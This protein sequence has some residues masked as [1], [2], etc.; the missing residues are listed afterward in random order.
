MQTQTLS[1]RSAGLYILL[2]AVTVSNAEAAPHRA[3]GGTVVGPTMKLFDANVSSCSEWFGQAHAVAVSIPASYL[4]ELIPAVE[5]GPVDKLQTGSWTVYDLWNNSVSKI[6]FAATDR[7]EDKL[8]AINKLYFGTPTPSVGQ[9]GQGFTAGHGDSGRCVTRPDFECFGFAIR[10][11]D[12]NKNVTGTSELRL[13]PSSDKCDRVPTAPGTCNF[14][15]ETLSIDF[16]P[17]GPSPA[18]K[19]GSLKVTCSGQANSGFQVSLGGGG[20]SLTSKDVTVKI[21]VDGH[22]LP[23]VFNWA[24]GSTNDLTVAATAT[25][26]SGASGPF[27]L[28]SVILLE[29]P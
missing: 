28:S 9:I 24:A 21:A 5:Y 16:G 6:S 12:A 14:T 22:P 27:R 23:Y 17:I 25:P 26:S 8:A 3:D 7:P 4:N 20:G 15:T 11:P 1:R 29:V 13:W 18:T 2:A 10:K 19:T